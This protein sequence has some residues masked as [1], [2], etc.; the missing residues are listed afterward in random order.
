MSSLKRLNILMHTIETKAFC[1]FE[2]IIPLYVSF[3][4]LCYGSMQPLEIIS[5][6]QRGIDLRR[7]NN[8]SEFDVYR[9]QIRTF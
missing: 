5:R 6:V 7:Q 1:Q 4:Y 8:T 3:E 9:R 2:I